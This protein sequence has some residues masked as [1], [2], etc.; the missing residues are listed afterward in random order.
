MTVE[1][2]SKRPKFCSTRESKFFLNKADYALYAASYLYADSDHKL[3]G[4]EPTLHAPT[5][6][7]GSDFIFAAKESLLTFR[8][9]QIVLLCSVQLSHLQL[10]VGLVCIYKQKTL[11]AEG[12]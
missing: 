9:A 3:A 8:Y 12:L 10:R 11:R 4:I 1:P 6:T 5:I 7:I 2:I